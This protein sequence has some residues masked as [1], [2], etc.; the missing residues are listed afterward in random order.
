MHTSATAATA[1]TAA[2]LP[3]VRL[4]LAVEVAATVRG[5]NDRATAS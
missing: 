2:T 3:A 1:A 4:A 5:L